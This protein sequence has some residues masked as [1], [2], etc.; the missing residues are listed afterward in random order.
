VLGIDVGGA[1]TKVAT[2]ALSEEHT[3]TA[4]VESGGAGG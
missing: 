3:R 1:N 4:G 2:S